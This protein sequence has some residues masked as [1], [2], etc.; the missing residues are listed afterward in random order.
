M[1][2]GWHIKV[3]PK[4]RHGNCNDG[5]GVEEKNVMLVSGVADTRN[6]DAALVKKS[7]EGRRYDTPQ[8]RSG[9]I[10]D[11]NCRLCSARK[12]M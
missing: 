2:E 11:V 3:S 5:N 7:N 8:D 6:K 9:A 1:Q 12:M 4:R 10:E